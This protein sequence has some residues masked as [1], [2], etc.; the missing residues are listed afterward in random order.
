MPF[1]RLQALGVLL[2]SLGAGAACFAQVQTVATDVPSPRT[3]LPLASNTYVVHPGDTITVTFRY[4][5]EFN[6]EVVVQP[7]GH[8]TLKATGDILVAGYTP[9][10]ITRAVKNGSTDK[11]VDPDVVV[12]VKDFERPLIVVAGEVQL[13]GKFELRKPTTALQ[14]VLLAGGPKEDAAMN[15]VYLFRHLNGDNSEVRELHLGRYDAR[16]RAKNDVPLQAG[17][18]LLIRHDTLE[19]ISRFLKVFNLG[20][21]INPLPSNGIQSLF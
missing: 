12:S 11:L 7:D 18:M 20:L 2:C 1:V 19:S 4:T 16:T 14:A 8:V 5:P 17:D 15:H 10:E 9:T 6:D 21:Y 13:P 3:A